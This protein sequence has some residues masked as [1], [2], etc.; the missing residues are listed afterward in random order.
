MS[1][2]I[3]DLTAATG[4]HHTQVRKVLRKAGMDA[5][6][7]DTSQERA[8]AVDILVAWGW[9]DAEKARHGAPTARKSTAAQTNGGNAREALIAFVEKEIIA[10]T[11]AELI[12]AD[13]ERRKRK[14]VSVQEAYALLLDAMY[15]EQ[16]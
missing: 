7:G 8:R 2:L 3:A 16:K 1:G 5:P 15:R 9:G 10:R 11:Q 12:C 13:I 6:Y 14:W 4:H